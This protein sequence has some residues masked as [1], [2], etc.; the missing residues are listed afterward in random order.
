MSD[1][2]NPSPAPE[3]AKGTGVLTQ[4]RRIQEGRKVCYVWPGAGMTKCAFPTCGCPTDAEQAPAKEQLTQSLET[5]RAILAERERCADIVR[6]HLTVGLSPAT[7]LA[8]RAVIEKIESG[9]QRIMSWRVGNKI[10]VNVYKDDRPVCQCQTSDDAA[11][12]VK[13]M[14]ERERC[15]TIARDIL[16]QERT[17]NVDGDRIYRNG[18]RHCA[19]AIIEKIGL[20]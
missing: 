7:E 8:V 10:P 2:V 17:G 5:S 15:L 4:S 18:W 19:E 14:N 12:I 1:P 6:A 11:R 16:S 9:G 3:G 13:T 20:A